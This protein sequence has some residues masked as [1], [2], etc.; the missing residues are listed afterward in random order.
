MSDVPEYDF[1]VITDIK[2]TK[3]RIT[4]CPASLY[5]LEVDWL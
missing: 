3:L 2:V 4:I 5:V 1:T